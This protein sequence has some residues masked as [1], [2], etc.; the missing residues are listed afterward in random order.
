M[1]RPRLAVL[2]SAAALVLGCGSSSGASPVL[3]VGTAA[4]DGGGSPTLVDT[5][6]ASG[7]ALALAVS[8]ASTSVCPG[9]CVD[10]SVQASGGVAPYTYAWSPAPAGSASAATVSVC[11]T[12]TTTY[13]VTVT[14]ASGRSATELATANAT[15]TTTATVSVPATCAADS[16]PGDAAPARPAQDAGVIVVPSTVDLWLAG[17][18]D[19]ASLVYAGYAT[20]VAPTNSPVEVPVVGGSTLTF[21]ATGST[22]YTGGIC[23]APSPDGGCTLTPTSTSPTNGLSDLAAPLNALIGVFLDDRVPVGQAP[24]ALTATGPN[25]FTSLSPLLKQTFFIG[26]GLT[27]TGTGAVQRFVVPQGATRLF[28]AS[29]DVVGGNQNNAGQFTVAISVQ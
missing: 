7:P 18:P 9:Q 3:D 22:S 29:S 19:G 14:D 13:Q 4:D 20:D 10:L 1:R 24:P 27:G 12:A 26:D 23:F 5:S 28:L 2:A 16:G 21:A 8:T 15:A 11:P 25:D 6:D 17:Q